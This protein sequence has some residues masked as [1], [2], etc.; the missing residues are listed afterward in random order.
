MKIATILGLLPTGL[1]PYQA[2]LNNGFLPSQIIKYHYSYLSLISFEKIFLQ[3]FKEKVRCSNKS[4]LLLQIRN[5]KADAKAKKPI[6]KV[7]APAA[8]K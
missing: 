7:T 6:P 2:T 8:R 5:H 4:Y 1:L 3:I